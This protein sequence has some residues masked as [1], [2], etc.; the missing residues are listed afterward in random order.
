MDAADFLL[1]RFERRVDG[2]IGRGMRLALGKYASV[3]VIGVPLAWAV[4]GFHWDRTAALGLVAGLV[5]FAVL[6][7]LKSIV[8]AARR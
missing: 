5:L 3:V 8:K 4:E 7:G 1:S 2:W 6:D